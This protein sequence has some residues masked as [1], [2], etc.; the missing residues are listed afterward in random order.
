MSSGELCAAVD[1]AISLII[2][3][4]VISA[5][6]HVVDFALTA[7]FWRR[8]W[9]EPMLRKRLA[10]CRQA[11]NYTGMIIS[12]SLVLATTSSLDGQMCNVCT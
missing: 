11:L 1:Q 7:Y 10:R 9:K 6:L 3:N 8:I 2:A 4:W 12:A 5:A